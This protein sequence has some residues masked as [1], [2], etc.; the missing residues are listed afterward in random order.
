M[1][2]LRD[3][4]LI[5]LIFYALLTIGWAVGGWLLVTHAFHWR[6]VERYVV[7]LVAG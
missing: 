1:Y 6:R 4:S 5:D 3:N 7:G 2:W